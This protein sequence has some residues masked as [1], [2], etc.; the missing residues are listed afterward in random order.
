MGDRTQVITT[1]DSGNLGTWLIDPADLTVVAAG[2][3]A[4]IAANTN[5]TAADSTINAS[6]V[7]NAL[8]GTNV[9]LQA[10]NSLTVD[11]VVD[12]S[13]NGAAGNL[14]LQ[15]PT[16]NLND[17]IL[18]E[19]SSQLTG[20]ATSVNLGIGGHLQNAVDAIATNGTINAAAATYQGSETFIDKSLTL[21]GQGSANTIFDGQGIRRLFNISAGDVTIDGV[22]V[23]NGRALRGDGGGIRV[24]SNGGLTLT[25]SLI[26]NNVVNIRSNSSSGGGVVFIAQVL[27]GSKT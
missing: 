14:R 3:T 7:V 23:Q 13:S 8:N 6:T 11:T 10:T 21:R 22:T 25:N 12:A 2:G 4:N 5:S 17:I 9:T 24:T 19:A 27:L 16:L 1:A 26:E 18:L 20:T 15:A